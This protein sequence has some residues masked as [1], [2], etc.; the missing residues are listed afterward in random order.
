M[1]KRI[2]IMI[3]SP[4]N[5]TRKICLAVASGMGVSN[6]ELTFFDITIP[7]TRKKISTIGNDCFK[8]I[9][10]LIVGAPVHSGKLPVQVTECL[11]A[12]R[13]NGKESI[14][15]VVYGNRSYGKA[16]YTMAVLL[17]ENGFKVIAAGAFIGQHSYSDI[18]PVASGRPDELDI[19]KA[20]QFGKHSLCAST[21]IKL[22]NVPIQHDKISKSDTYTAIKPAHIQKLCNQ[23][24]KCSIKCPLELLSPDTG[25]YLNP[26]SKKKC[27]GCMTCVHACIHNAKVAKVNLFVKIIMKRIFKQALKE[28]KD[29]LIIVS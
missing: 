3:F 25:R 28:R 17:Y 23:C 29:P 13:G 2:G 20:Y 27:I 9:D 8:D 18:V 10:L 15:I 16:L 22:E 7:Q 12:L 5:T 24:G 1:D 4:T 14:A 26:D 6:N 19:E 11:Q 21:N